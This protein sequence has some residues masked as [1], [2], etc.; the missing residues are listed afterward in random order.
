MLKRILIV[1]AVI[2]VLFGLVVA[3]Q[4]SEYRVARKVVI[5]APPS[6]VFA[7]VNDFRKWEAWNPWGKID[8]AMKQT[9]EGT[10]AG[11]GAVYTWAGNG[12]VGE[13]RMT[14]TES[15]PPELIRVR[16]DFLRPF[17]GTSTAEFT[18]QPEGKPGGGQTAVTWSM[19]GRNNLMAKAVHLFMDMDKMIGDQFEAGLAHMKAVAEATATQ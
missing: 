6:A 3:M 15:R 4:P 11:V 1:L 7:H 12:D 19:A 13:G 2:V 14:L 9:Y 18:F 10:P 17:A 8:P 16:L 5:A